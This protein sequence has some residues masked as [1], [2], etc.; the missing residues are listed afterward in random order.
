MHTITR[1]CA[2][3]ALF[4][5]ILLPS[6]TNQ[7]AD[8]EVER[9]CVTHVDV[10][11]V[12]AA[13]VSASMDEI[14][15]KAQR[16]GHIDALLHPEILQAIHE[17]MFGCIAVSYIEW[18][19]Q[20]LV[21]VD[22]YVLK[23]QT[24]V[25]ELVEHLSHAVLEPA[26]NE[27]TNIASALSF[28]REL[29]LN[30]KYVAPRMVIDISGDGMNT[31]SEELLGRER[32]GVIEAGITINGLAMMFPGEEA[33]TLRT[34]QLNLPWYFEDCVIGGMGAFQVSVRT[35]R[36]FPYSIRRKLLR[37]IAGL[38]AVPMLQQASVRSPVP[39]GPPN[40]NPYYGGAFYG[41]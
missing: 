27:A 23:D 22:W 12:L 38:D 6:S 18:A 34:G 1:C 39:C 37:E 10:E 26:R 17:G 21:V 4:S 41:R 25:S 2:L 35:V 33:N 24:D 16:Q 9:P 5:F 28:A 7:A 32:S 3:C 20:Q 19:S 36:D 30:N 31:T 29:L 40:A 8:Y 13:D 11:L 15:L 14:E